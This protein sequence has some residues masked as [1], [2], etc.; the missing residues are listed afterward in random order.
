M[1]LI[2]GPITATTAARDVEKA[3][4]ALP[5][6]RPETVSVSKMDVTD[7]VAYTVTFNSVRGR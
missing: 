7:G 4:N 1:Q 6:I 5:S 3:L 2:A